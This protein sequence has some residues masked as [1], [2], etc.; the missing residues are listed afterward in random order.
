MLFLEHFR[1]TSFGKLF[2]NLFTTEDYSVKNKQI[3]LFSKHLQREVYLH[4]FTPTTTPFLTTPLPLLLFNDGQDMQSLRLASTIEQLSRIKKIPQLM[5]VAI[6]AGDRMQEY[7]TTNVPDYQNRGSK[8]FAYNQFVLQELLPHLR[9][10]YRFTTDRK[11]ISF[12]GC[13][14]GG[15][16]ALDIVWQNPKQFGSVGVFSGALWW[17]EKAFVPHAPDADRIMHRLVAEALVP[18]P[19]RFWFQTG[20]ADETS[21]RNNNGVIDSIDDTLDLID[22]LHELGYRPGKAI[23]YVEIDEGRHHPDTW[24]D[25]LPD[26]LQYAFGKP[27]DRQPSILKRIKAVLNQF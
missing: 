18:P 7:G 14:L 4:I 6:V 16:S 22:I 8:A 25:A 23:R 21:D 11:K 27:R 5:V 26:F 3:Q 19:L 24:A 12:A 1:Q 15:L 17:R 2:S 9:K 20:T 13:S 10:R